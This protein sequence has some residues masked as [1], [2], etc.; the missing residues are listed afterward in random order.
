MT[1]HSGQ[2]RIG[3]CMRQQEMRR[4]WGGHGDIA[5]LCI[6]G[7]LIGATFDQPIHVGRF[8]AL[9]CSNQLCMCFTT[10]AVVVVVVVA[11]REGPREYD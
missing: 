6:F 7:L 4:L 2:Q 10:A 5:N 9:G 8:A 11:V 3:T 1:C